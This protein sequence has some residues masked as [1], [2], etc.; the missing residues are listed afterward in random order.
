MKEVYLVICFSDMNKKGKGNL[1]KNLIQM[2]RVIHDLCHWA[3][4]NMINHI[5]MTG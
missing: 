2:Y 5:E 3:V 4:M 1:T